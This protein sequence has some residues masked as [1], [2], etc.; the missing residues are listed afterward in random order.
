MKFIKSIVF[1][2]IQTACFAQSSATA[3]LSLTLPDVAYIKLAPDNSVIN[4]TSIVPTSNGGPLTFTSNNSKYINFT[5]AVASGVNRTITVQITSGSLPSGMS[6]KLT[7]SRAGGG[8]GQ[9]G[10]NITSINLTSNQENIITG[11]GSAYTGQG[12]GFGY[13]LSY[14]LVISD[15]S[16]LR[17][18]STSLTITFTIT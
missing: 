10:T 8:M 2:L 7:V 3:T 13:N 4:L 5:S 17:A 14:E 11:I 6:L 12:F 18:G 9:L 15:Y 16:Q 1:I